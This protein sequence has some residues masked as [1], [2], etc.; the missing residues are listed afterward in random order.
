MTSAAIV[1]NN[2]ELSFAA[3]SNLTSGSTSLDENRDG[4][5]NVAGGGLT[6]AQATD[7]A[8]RFPT[9]I[10]QYA[11]TLA[12]GG[13]ST[14]FNATVFADVN[15][16]L[17]LAIRGT[18]SLGIGGDTSDL[19][20]GQDIV[21]NGMAYDQIV[22]LVNWWNRASTAPGEMVNQFRLVEMANHSIP[23][24]AVVMRPGTNTDTSYV[25]DAAS[26]ILAFSEE[27][28]ISAQLAADPDQRVEVTGHS[29]G[30]HLG[31]A[32][33]TLFAG[34]TGQVTVFNTPGFKDNAINRAFMVKL[35]G[36]IPAA[37][38]ANIVNVIADETTIGTVQYDLVAGMHSKPGTVFSISIENQ[39]QSDE[40][41]PP[42]ALNHSI[43]T[44]TDSLAIYKLLADLAPATGDNAFTTAAYKGILNQAVQGTAAG[45]ERIVDALE[46]LFTGDGALLDTGNNQR[47]TLYQAIQAL[48]ADGS[49]YAGR[50]GQL[51]IEAITGAA[52]VFVENAQATGQKG[53]AW[54]YALME[55]DPFVVLD[56]SGTGVYVR[57]QSSGTN[58]GE[59]D[60]HNPF[61]RTGTLT[62]R[63]LE[64]R[65]A[66]LQ[67]KLD[68]AARDEINNIDKPLNLNNTTKTWAAD[69]LYFEDRT[70]GYI[71]NQ[72]ANGG[73]RA[74][75]PYIIFGS[76]RA[77]AISGSSRAD[78]L[79]GGGGTDYLIGKGGADY[80]EGGT[81][82]DIYEYS[83]VRQGSSG[84][85]PDGHDSILD[86]D[87]RGVL[88]YQYNDVNGKQQSTIIGGLALKG[89]DGKWSTADGQFVFET[90]GAD[91]KIAFS[92][93]LD[94]SITIKDY[95]E[96][97]LSIR[98]QETRADPRTGAEILGDY[99]R[100]PSPVTRDAF[101]N[102]EISGPEVL[103][104]ADILFG[105]RPDAGMPVDPNAQGEKFLSGGGNDIIL[106]D[107]PRGE[108]DNGL[109]NADWII[110]GAGRDW[111]EAGAGN[112]LIE[113]GADADFVDGGSGDDEIYADSKITLSEAIRRG[114]EDAPTNQKGDFLSGGAGR[115]WIIGAAGDDVLLGGG[116]E[117]LIMG[118]AGDDTIRS[119]LGWA[120]NALDWTVTRSVTEENG[121]RTYLTT[122]SDTY[123]TDT[124][125]G[126][127]D[128]IYGGK[129]AD[130][131][132]AG[133][134]DDFIDGGA[135]DDVLF[136]EA[137]S[138][139]LIGGTGNDVLTGDGQDLADGADGDD[140]LDGGDGDDQLF[141]NGG[142]DIL[143]GGRGNDILI[144]GAG[145]DIYVFNKGDG[146]DTVVDVPGDS[147]TADASLLVLGEGFS[148]G[149]IK[150]RTGS[151]LVDLGPA[152]S[153]DP[154]SP[155]DMIHFEGFDQYDPRATPLL[156]EIRFAD[157]T[158]MSYEDI[159][160]QGFDIDG[161]EGDDDG[162]NTDHPML[163][164]TGVTDRIRGFGG[165]D[166]LLGADG[167]DVL[168]GGSGND[169]LQ[170]GA[171]NDILLGGEDNDVLLGENGDDVL[172][173][174]AGAD[175]L[176]G[177]PGNDT[178][179]ADFSDTIIDTEGDN[180]IQFAAD[181]A[182]DSLRAQNLAINGENY[183]LLYQ[184]GTTQ[185]IPGI[186]DGLKI[187]GDL[188]QL[189]FSFALAGSAVLS[190]QQ[191]LS[192]AFIQDLTITGTN[193]DDALTGYAGNDTL[194]GYSGNDT[195]TGGRG[196][197]TLIGYDGSDTY[198]FNRGD[199]QDTIQENG[200][201]AIGVPD[202][203]SIDAIRFGAGITPAE[204]TLTRRA[205][206]DL[207]IAYGS[208]DRITVIG[209]YTNIIN[210]IERIEFDDDTVIDV[211][212]LAALPIAPI[213]GSAGDDV[214]GGTTA[215]DTLQGLAGNDTLDGG[216]TER[217][218][219][220]PTGN[221]RLEG[222]AGAD[223]YAMYLGMGQDTLIDASASPEETSTLAIE[224]GLSFDSLKSTRDGDD[225]IV[226]LRGTPDSAR[227]Q[228]YYDAAAP[229]HWQIGLADGTTIPID[230]LINR[231]DPY[232]DN[233]ALQ[234][235]EDYRQGVLA[236]WNA[237]SR[238]LTLPTHALVFQS[239][240]QTTTTYYT[241]PA[242]PPLVTVLPP[243]EK[244]V[245]VDYG[246]QQGNGYGPA[247]SHQT[248]ITPIAVSQQSDDASIGPVG[249]PQVTEQNFI[250]RVSWGNSVQTVQSS[251][252]TTGTFASGPTLLNTTVSFNSTSWRTIGLTLN[253]ITSFD[254]YFN[255]TQI[256]EQRVVEEITAGDSN[257]NIHAVLGPN[258]VALVDAGGGDDY[259]SA[260]SNDFVYG[261]DGDDTVSGGYL[262]YGGD[263]D[264]NLFYGMYL[265]GGA[266]NDILYDG[267]VMSG[268]EGD[269][270]MYGGYGLTQY[271][272]NS[273][274]AGEDY[275]A[276]YAGI[277]RSEYEYDEEVPFTWVAAN[278]YELLEQFY[279]SGLIERDT[280]IFGPGVNPEDVIVTRNVDE[281]T[282]SWGQGKLLHAALAQPWDGIGNGIEQFSFANGETWSLREALNRNL[283]GT[284]TDGDDAIYYTE[285]DDIAF[286]LAGN[287]A[288]YGFGGNDT[289]N[290]GAGDDY[291]SGGLGSDTYVFN[292]GYGHDVIEENQTRP[293]D[294]DTIVFG[295]GI[296]PQSVG[297]L[298]VNN[299]L[300]VLIDGTQDQLTISQWFAGSDYRV[301]RVVFADGTEW[302]GAV[303]ESLLPVGVITGSTG[304]DL[305]GGTPGDDIIRGLNGNDVLFGY[306]G[307][308]TLDGGAGDDY[309][310][311][312]PGDD[313]YIFRFGYGIDTIYDESGND[314]I[315][316]GA[317]ITP[318][319]L[320]LGLD[321][322]SLPI[323]VGAGGDALHIEGFNPNDVYGSQVIENFVF[324]GGETL[325]YEELIARGIHIYG[326]DGDDYLSGTN[327]P[328]IIDGGAGNDDL[329]GAD[330]H[331]IL[332]GGPGDDYLQGGPGDDIYV[333]QRGDG[334]DTVED[335]DETP[336]NIDIVRFGADIA[337]ADVT[338]G[339]DYGDL[340]LGVNGSDD[341]VVLYGWYWDDDLKVEQV[342]FAN[343]T[344]WDVAALE[345][346]VPM[347][348]AT[349]DDDLI[350]GTSG[351]D[352]IDGLGGNDEIV[353]VGGNDLLIG[354]TGN[355]Y[356][357]GGGG[358]D[359]L[360][361]GDDVDE[362]EDWNGSNYFDGGNGDDTVLVSGGTGF[363]IGGR[364]NDEIQN[365]A[366]G[367]MV[368]AFNARDGHDTIYEDAPLTLSLGGGIQAANLSLR[369]DGADM[370]LEIGADD[371]IRLT[372]EWVADPHI[373]PQLTLQLIDGA[374]TTYS[375]NEL[376]NIYKYLQASDPDLGS[377]AISDALASVQID[378]STEF[379]LG[380][381]L[382]YRYAATGSNDSLTP[383]AIR[384]I[385]A[386]PAFGIAPQPFSAASPILTGTAGD[387]VLSG[388]NGPDILF[389]GAGNDTLDGGA[390]NDSYVFGLG[391]GVDVIRDSS[392]EDTIVFGAGITPDM[393]S[394]GL[395]SLQIRVGDGGDAIHIEGFDP[396]D[397]YGTPVIENFAFADHAVLTY[398]DLLARGFDITGTGGNDVLSGTNIADRISGLG[399]DDTL[400]GGDGDD[401]LD[402]GADNDLLLGGAGSDTYYFGR[403]SG[404][405]TIEDAAGDYDA[406]VLGDTITPDD[407]TVTRTDDSLSLRINGTSDELSILWQPQDGYR[408]EQVRFADGTE[409]DAATLEAQANRAPQT[410]ASL[411]AV[412]ATEDASFTYTLSSN[413]FFDPDANDQ[414]TL[415]A[416]LIDGSPLPSWLNFDGVNF[417][418]LPANANVGT[419]GIKV[420]A[421]DRAGLSVASAFTLNVENVNDAPTLANAIT[422]QTI[423]EDASFSFVVPA[424]TFADIDAGDG[425]GYG[426][427]LA[428]GTPLPTW[429]TFDPASQT[430][431]GT[432][433]NDD[434][435]TL[436][437]TVTA[438]DSGGLSVASAFTLNVENVNDA[439]TLAN[440]IIDLTISEDV[441]FSFVVP[442]DTF[443][444][445]DAGDVLTY[446]ATLADGSALPAWLSFDA[447]Q[448]AFNGTPENGDVGTLEVRVTATDQSGANVSN[449]FTLIV[450]NINDAP[451]VAT[452]IADPSTLEDVPFTFT[453]P[454]DTF[455]D[456]DVGD[457]L[458]F[459]AT[460]ADGSPLPEWLTFDPATQAFTGTPGNDEV[461]TLNVTV[462][463]TDTAD[464]RAADK[465][466]LTVVNVNDA[467][468]LIN[469]QQNQWIADGDAMQFQLPGNAFN[470]IDA[471]DTL[472]YAAAQ[473]D[474]TPLP[475]WLAFDAATRT[476]SGTPD[477]AD[478]GTLSLSVTA[479][480]TIG[481]TASD[482]FDLDVTVAPD[483]TYT[484][485]GGDDWLY[486]RSGSDTLNGLAG[487]DALSGR[488][489]NDILNGGPGDDL[490]AGGTGDDTYVYQAGDGLDTIADEAG[491][492][493]VAFGAGLTRDNVVA[494]LI[495]DNTTARIRVL[496]AN[497]NEQADQGL[498]IELDAGG[499]SPV[500]W[501]TFATG[502]PA[503]L[504]D[505]LIRQVIRYGTQRNDVI[506][507]G[508]N[509]DLIY[510]DR[511]NDTVYA[512]TG[513]DVVFGDRGRDILYGE[514]GND[515]LIGGRGKDQ[516]YGGFGDDVLEGGR[517]TD[518]L[519]GGAGFNTYVFE[520]NFGDDRIV[521]GSGSGAL[522][523][524]DGISTRDLS[525]KRRNNDLVVK[526][527]GEGRVRIEG[528][529]DKN[530]V[531][532]VEFAEFADGTVLGADKFVAK[533]YDTER[534]R[535]EDDDDDDGSHYSNDD[536]GSRPHG[537]SK[538][539]DRAEMRP[540]KSA[541]GQGK[542]SGNSDS[543][544]FDKVA[545]KWN[546]NYARTARQND[547]SGSERGGAS[548]GTQPVNRWQRMH[549][550]LSAHLADG[551]DDADNSGADL[552]SLKPGS[553][554]GASFAQ[555]GTTGYGGIGVQDRGAADLRPFAGLREGLARIA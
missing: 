229:Q 439:P 430:F 414:L 116:G 290:G 267:Q 356:L 362:L 396:A 64:D 252:V 109:G 128:V 112:D 31:L 54:R 122:F 524:G 418:G 33:S 92:G 289:L 434:V 380:G 491:S 166:V 552:A 218:A 139:I 536:G 404:A 44:L 224:T 467:P 381:N 534:E 338:V 248:L 388:G 124:S 247:S 372:R 481:A 18:D 246:V 360:L 149:D 213:T 72:G 270:A 503:T 194:S 198:L 62:V 369:R 517:G 108:A 351:E 1:F 168:D 300:V 364:G 323:A 162:H 283:V 2:A 450:D 163:S 415:S 43:V 75:D 232:A 446:G 254:S 432:P 399:G 188:G 181:V 516:L 513:N 88:R 94:G 385:L 454:A 183:L 324:T 226:G 148:K 419:V 533:G 550:R 340:V 192:A 9:I 525:F 107:R 463:A 158:S 208:S 492:D 90:A 233:I 312:G 81:G 476:F 170:G 82:L 147:G 398:N 425:L 346:M 358:N 352:V 249:R 306:E 195:L 280:V 265:Y 129:G 431:S 474:G 191:L 462:T 79:Y 407:L 176:D 548:R 68:I 461:G 527:K 209:Q 256:N 438:T 294:V 535:D 515:V 305:L 368:V 225:L 138:D 479:T 28:N 411:V 423:S 347:A 511:G 495:E 455:A 310:D 308:D 333:F 279:A 133:G 417:S 530:A 497:G 366:S 532:Q 521:R 230:D 182:L 171:G 427:T 426:A 261:N 477:E 22:A 487:N 377:W 206:G 549:D 273:G 518:I 287:D 484:G 5:I 543:A 34:Q 341:Q 42:S 538:N 297:A 452:A 539:E 257:N 507:T 131:I 244:K 47:E 145:K 504:D 103:N 84:N 345:A 315:V 293:S 16:K 470:D 125:A 207:V 53:L 286:G 322:A 212:Q 445:I 102:L 220:Q 519:D 508:R 165:N 299:D 144:G 486:G 228:G 126:A 284:A 193:G 437:V 241:N 174:G 180:R 274:E 422:D 12:N 376:I 211:D 428:D 433:G 66:L 156:S 282:L 403:G 355:D 200:L 313:T 465:F 466:D 278:D 243:V 95:K 39:W 460:L 379:A 325:T 55:L 164:G 154:N 132:F 29:L 337:P 555:F 443:A 401:T 143:I 56:E 408:I 326:S 489:G 277:D 344:V 111:I 453:L 201:L 186:P 245:L 48:T 127:A 444:D 26:Q 349:E 140:Y 203:Q 15:G 106:A 50:K 307:N 304:D 435:E 210:V 336:G 205:D 167:D 502:A 319:M 387:D 264:D 448:A 410:G 173:G 499:S 276:D 421:T 78:R 189:N 80:L 342:A 123:V 237:L 51:K 321:W 152:D 496:D 137:G 498:D 459:S 251:G 553:A 442:A 155:R 457:A 136:G 63:W 59:L 472:S 19:A 490:L 134:G 104:Q 101:G 190:Q 40:P 130:W 318:D 302:D 397:V 334:Y 509:D 343:G 3:Y 141:G 57:F 117:D 482:S 392:G 383:D 500:E 309:L 4:L 298:R 291:L 542:H 301:E 61:D 99:Q 528:W 114:N 329:S 46:K 361:G 259:V 115:D 7:F 20:A 374:V 554:H 30:G 480:D 529:F 185:T 547:E 384:S 436:S 6:P 177:G 93:G 271:L 262:V 523:F 296:T 169:H 71:I 339:N 60:L 142:S 478:I 234:A 178:Y 215:D 391:D 545:E 375:L 441:S 314:T 91:L 120:A 469:H 402:G 236:G 285:N 32:F 21:F 327:G 217:Y 25:L 231:V 175:T 58:A 451:Q 394:L 328:D 551:H 371:S 184:A 390:G 510:A 464:A 161:T 406:V 260:D 413:A 348:E 69:N 8:R 118:G 382:A 501:F 420:T 74:H 238:P 395:G 335:W 350:F 38:A 493:T 540:A 37:G 11:D 187:K 14:G 258:H 214:L 520:R 485:T 49:A 204:V 447:A 255:V 370:V 87:G 10:T 458:T 223:R 160:A 393:L 275:I 36:M 110:A 227:I 89:D 354:G 268:G 146:I 85:S 119:D 23:A 365:Y 73:Q 316:F 135:D 405:D 239:W 266:G 546:G 97:D 378:T 179:L 409:W 456:V 424:D 172:D 235:R 506:R 76:D 150:F 253:P 471:G 96:G 199:G 531:H 242:F 77:D 221:D 522:R 250:Y 353:G 17:T 295:P 269:D 526:V 389:G 303:L 67:R 157:G 357:G 544:W 263:G 292:L 475:A 98:L 494:R 363:V 514:A 27:R 100:D 429:L 197:D 159:L 83:S 332:I 468:V 196:D 272:I 505:L 359:I 400:N 45:Y 330:G 440:A 222:G 331:D 512:G 373:W 386:D 537:A 105:G 65:A 240:S 483:T 541:S 151:L 311:G 416:T 216:P 153:A 288:L 52:G 113:A 41:A 412:T 202:T 35:G 24:G 281:I 70:T 13:M 320:T 473:A 449:D 219:G 86:V 317:G 488:S 367:S 121:R